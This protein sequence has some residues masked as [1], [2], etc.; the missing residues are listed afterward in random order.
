LKIRPLE[1]A[2][3]H[4]HR[5]L[6]LR[7]L[8]ESP[9][10]FA[11]TYAEQ[12]ARP[13]DSWAARLAEASASGCD[14]PLL[15]EL[16]GEPVGMAWARKDPTDASVV[17]IFQVWVDPAARGRGIAAGLMREAIAW[18]RTRGARTVQLDVTPGDTAA[19]R[20]YLREG[21]R[22]VGE[23]VPVRPG[24]T[25]LSQAMRLDL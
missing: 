23:P 9:E 2:D 11:T 24:A 8:Q 15:A 3:W 20:L 13:D 12:A 18:A 1:P 25:L 21:F 10:A 5:M 19:A 6:R 22:N 7:A 14:L 17:E 16:D 4:T